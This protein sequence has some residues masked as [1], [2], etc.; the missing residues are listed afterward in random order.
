MATSGLET[1]VVTPD[2]CKKTGHD[3]DNGYGNWTGHSLKNGTV[4]NFNMTLSTTWNETGT[5][6]LI[7]PVELGLGD[8][9]DGLFAD[10]GHDTIHLSNMTGDVKVKNAI[11]AGTSSPRLKNGKLK[12]SLLRRCPGGYPIYWALD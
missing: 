7:D 11:I 12:S 10:Y 1:I 5:I 3:C 8:D 2:A 6:S 4:P 9:I